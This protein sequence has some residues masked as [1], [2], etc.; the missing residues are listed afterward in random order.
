MSDGDE[1]VDKLLE[2]KPRTKMV[3]ATTRF[4]PPRANASTCDSAT[5]IWQQDLLSTNLFLTFKAPTQKIADA[6]SE[7]I[8]KT[9]GSTSSLSS[10]YKIRK[11]WATANIF[12]LD[13]HNQNLVLQPEARMKEPQRSKFAACCNSTSMWLVRAKATKRKTPRTKRRVAA[14]VL[15]ILIM[16]KC[17]QFPGSCRI[18][19]SRMKKLFKLGLICSRSIPTN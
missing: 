9:K 16:W 6:T 1:E 8:P 3:S 5:D 14:M 19:P 18:F 15:T 7:K 13:R 4:S 12:Y 17:S 11:H 2:D 10:K